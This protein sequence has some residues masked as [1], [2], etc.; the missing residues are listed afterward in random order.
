MHFDSGPK[1]LCSQGILEDHFL[2]SL[3][4]FSFDAAASKVASFRKPSFL[5]IAIAVVW[6]IWKETNGFISKIKTPVS[7][8]RRCLL[9]G[10]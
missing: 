2:G 6:H 10:N 1:V 9:K 4:H 5:E 7:F 3:A 8:V